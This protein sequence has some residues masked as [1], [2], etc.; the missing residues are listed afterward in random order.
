MARTIFSQSGGIAFMNTF[1]SVVRNG[2]E[3]S[4]LVFIDMKDPCGLYNGQEKG[5]CYIKKNIR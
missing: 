1:F 3:R 2:M 5:R 4:L